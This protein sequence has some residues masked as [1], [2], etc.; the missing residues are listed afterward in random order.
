MASMLGMERTHST[1]PVQC[2]GR[3]GNKERLKHILINNVVDASLANI[4]SS[5]GF[6]SAM[7]ISQLCHCGDGVQTS[8]LGKDS[9]DH[10]KGFSKSSE[11]I[12]ILA[13]H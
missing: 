10:F 13:L 4:D 3:G 6:P 2:D 7:S 12:C 11:A 8:I 9:W 1:Q 5:V